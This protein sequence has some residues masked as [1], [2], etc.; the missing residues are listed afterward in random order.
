LQQGPLRKLILNST[1]SV[2]EGYV[3]ADQHAHLIG[4]T[5]LTLTPLRPS[6]KIEIDGM[7]YEAK[8][9]FGWVDQGIKVEVTGQE[10]FVLIVEPIADES[11]KSTEA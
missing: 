1:Q 4:T 2:E 6:G 5:A 9:T 8:A 3:V 7:A 11:P 10:R